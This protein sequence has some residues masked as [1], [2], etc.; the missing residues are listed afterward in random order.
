MHY[1]E[2]KVSWTRGDAKFTDNKY[3][4]AHEW[5]FDGGVS[6]RASSSPAVVPLPLSA[7]DAV[8]PE[9]ALVAAA[10]SC[11]MLW[12]L[13]IAARK[14]FVVD[15]YVDEARGEIGKNADGKTAVT[16][17]ALRPRIGFSGEKRPTAADLDALHHA[18]HE[19]CFIAS[20]LKS[21][22]VVEAQS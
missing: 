16:R 21:E 8:D 2:A 22:V 9:E 10:S 18:A 17:I 15:S 3:S 14:G 20:S 13:S 4:R 5:K 7:A 11:H 12:F 6:V 19:Q 1:H